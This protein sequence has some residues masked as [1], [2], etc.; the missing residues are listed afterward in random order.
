MIPFFLLFD[1]KNPGPR[2]LLWLKVYAICKNDKKSHI[3]TTN[4]DRDLQIAPKDLQWP[5]LYSTVTY[6]WAKYDILWAIKENQILHIFVARFCAL[7]QQ[8]VGKSHRLL[9]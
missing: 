8:E 6:H 1:E 7:R 3:S 9:T 2:A 4:E 5:H